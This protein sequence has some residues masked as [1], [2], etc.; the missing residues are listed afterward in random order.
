MSKEN[1]MILTAHQPAYLPWL[2]LLHKIALSDVFCVFD[3]VQYQTKSF[4]NRNKIKT[5]SGSIWLTVPV[6]SSGRL[7]SIITDIKIIDDGWRKKHIKSIELNYKKTPYF[8]KY[9][10]K[11]KE[12]LEAPHQHLSDLNYEMLIYLLNVLGINTQ[13]VKASD[14]SFK[15]SGSELVLDM[16]VQLNA[17][18]YIFGEQ[19]A[20]YA[21]LDAFNNKGV[22]PYFQ[23][24]LHP[25][26]R[27]IKG[28]FEPYMGAIDL[29]FNHGQNSQEIIMSNNVSK[30]DII[31][32][33]DKV[34]NE[35]QN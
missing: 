24:Y 13:V 17:N 9:F 31:R 8:E 6:S 18:I 35:I 19:G 15:G 32:S 2:G 4:Q 23:S 25:T 26:Y 16:C 27:Q 22:F 20:N 30:L 29:I 14:Y 33:I 1:P 34:R 28:N 10:P 11:F 21:D 7:E 5:S 3:S 12:I